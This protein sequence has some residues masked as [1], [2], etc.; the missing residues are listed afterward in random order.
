MVKKAL[1]GAADPK[2][3]MRATTPLWQFEQQV[4][5]DPRWQFTKNAHADTSQLLEQLGHDWGYSAA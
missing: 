3:G 5:S 4:K 1:Q 2:T